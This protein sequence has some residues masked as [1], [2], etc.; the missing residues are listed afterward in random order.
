VH[1]ALDLC[2]ACKGCSTDCPTGID[3]ATYKAEALH[4]KYRR[5]LR[6]R[7]HY[8]LGRLPRWARLTRPVVPVA[9]R[10][11]RLK[12][13][14]RLAKAAAGI[15]Q[16]RGIPAFAVRSLSR[17][18]RERAQTSDRPDVVV[19]ADSFTEHFA[20]GPGQAAVTL[21]EGTGLNVAV[22]GEDA[23]CG[24]TWIS[25][26]Q[27]DAARRI[28]S[29]TVDVLHPYVAAGVPVVGLEPSCTAALRAD[30]VQLTDDP[31]AVE[32]ARGVRT[33]AE[34]LES[35]PDWS[36]PD[37]SGTTVVAQ[38]HCHHASVLGW[39]ADA[40][41]LARAGATVTRVGGCCGLAGNFGVEK[42]HYEVSVAIAEHSLLP[43]V[44]SAGP[45]AV[46]LADGFSCRTQLDDLAGV[47]AV[48]LSEL[49][50]G[51]DRRRFDPAPA[52]R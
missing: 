49:L 7:S 4:Q 36:P 38:P 51:G 10:A 29:H 37:L 24:L 43:A 32:L 41:L 30:L 35:L 11:L 31:R 13:V 42:G 34:M 8:A 12:P 17:W 18:A 45:D 14:Q 47:A 50:L 25:T 6:P 46:V 19:W 20:T 22:V 27:L 48:H 5:R 23:C 39:E 26:G 1:E 28:V 16:R 40:R 9:N 15:D 2:L 33:L 21:L 3:M 52:S 44:R